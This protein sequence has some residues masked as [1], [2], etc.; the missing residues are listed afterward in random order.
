M[1]LKTYRILYTISLIICTL[2]TI[3]GGIFLIFSI[4]NEWNDKSDNVILCLCFLVLLVFNMFQVYSLIHSFKNGSIFFRNI[5]ENSEK[6]L[7]TGLLLFTNLLLV[8]MIGLFVYSILLALGF[9]IPF[10]TFA[11]ANDFLI[12]CFSLMA[13]VNLI[14][15]DLYILVYDQED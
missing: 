11:L 3:A 14:F 12:S 1:K 2:A 4:I 10:S 13:I 8:L 9:D 5:I 7:N 15:F 6:N